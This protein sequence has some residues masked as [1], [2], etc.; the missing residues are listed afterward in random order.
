MATYGKRSGGGG[1]TVTT[2]APVSGDG[3]A[4]SPVTI[5]AT[6]DP[7]V[8][9]LTATRLLT[10]NGSGAAPNVRLGATADTGIYGSGA[11][12]AIESA[13]AVVFRIP[14]SQVDLFVLPFGGQLNLG[15]G[16]LATGSTFGFIATPTMAGAPTGAPTVAGTRVAEVSDTTNIKRWRM[17][18]AT[19]DWYC[20]DRCGKGADVA[21]AATTVIAAADRTAFDYFQLTGTTTIDH[22][23]YYAADAYGAIK[24]GEAITF[25][26]VTG[27]TINNNTATPPANSHAFQNVGAANAVLGAGS[28]ICYRRDNALAKWVEMWR[29]AA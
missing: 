20:V 29:T 15:A 24:D 1:G 21:S 9:V 16:P 28:K 10:S 27:L 7:T 19:D 5:A 13:G 23:G 4:G 11:E 17:M 18:P 6:A 14:P 25:Y 2:S 26:V 8:D 12:V 22:L 3:S